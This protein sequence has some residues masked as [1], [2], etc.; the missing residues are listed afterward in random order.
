MPCRKQINGD[1]IVS[2]F[3]FV[4]DL[5][6]VVFVIQSQRNSFHVQQA[7]K[8]R[9]DLLQQ[10]QALQEVLIFIFFIHIFTSVFHDHLTSCLACVPKIYSHQ[11]N[12]KINY[13]CNY[14]PILSMT[15]WTITPIC[16][17]TFAKPHLQY[18][19]KV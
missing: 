8:L 13:L 2:F 12:P 6:E 11:F 16:Y 4:V 1:E 17:E 9:K 18:L 5:K 10:T 14:A 3:L 15:F 19:S 7:E